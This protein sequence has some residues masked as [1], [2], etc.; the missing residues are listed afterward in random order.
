M[1]IARLAIHHVRIPFRR[2]IRHASHSRRET[3]SLVACCE[4]NDGS[5]GWGEGLP[6]EY[7]TGETI[8]DA[9]RLLQSPA[10]AERLKAL[11]DDLDAALEELANLEVTSADFDVRVSDF[12][13]RQC[14]GN[15]LR[16]AIETAVLDALCRRANVPLS[17]VTSLVPETKLIRQKQEEVRYSGIVT[18]EQPLR[19]LHSALKQRIYGFHQ[20]KIKVGVAG[21]DD[22]SALKRIRR[23]CGNG[24]DLRIDA[25]EAFSC[26]ELAARLRPM[27]PVCL[28][29]VEQPVPHAE[30]AGL[31]EIRSDFPI[32]ITL[33]E[34]V[35][36]HIDAQ[37][38]IDDGLCDIFN[39]RLSKCG[40][41]LASLK[42]AAT[43]QAAGLD[44]QLGCQVGETGILS[45]AGRHFATS[46]GGLRYLEGS[47]DRHLVRERLTVED[48]TFGYGGCASAIDRAGLGVSIDET[49]LQRVAVRR[50]Q[51]IN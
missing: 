48:L 3:H 50:H 8:D 4:L 13:S 23:I 45:A 36:S 39:I 16:C 20:L 31:A 14:F 15:S 33:D 34:S 29:S 51:L 30:V 19:Q 21:R 9:W 7:V 37:V 40:G 22:V 18:A 49:A 25:N 17:H 27:M 10:I 38:A 24:V 12:I 1:S 35:C 41:F 11:P 44:C 26:D 42:L 47:Y 6:R 5:V 46:V 43:A 28:S 2:Q 32:D